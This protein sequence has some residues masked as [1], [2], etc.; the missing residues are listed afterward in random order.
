MGNNDRYNEWYIDTYLKEEQ[1]TMISAG[2]RH[3]KDEYGFNTFVKQERNPDNLNK[4]ENMISQCMQK[5]YQEELLET[6]DK[7]TP[8]LYVDCSQKGEDDIMFFILKEYIKISQA[9]NKEIILAKAIW[10]NSVVISTEERRKYID[11]NKLNIEEIVSKYIQFLK[12]KSQEKNDI[13]DFK[14]ILDKEIYITFDGLNN[15]MKQENQKYLYLY[16]DK[17]DILTWDEQR[18]INTLLYTRWS[19]NDIRIRVKINNGKWTWK[20]RT[21]STWNR[22]QSTHDYTE[23][24]IHEEKL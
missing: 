22:I 11:E 16:L 21:S 5:R 24:I 2:Y 3:L 6:L 10:D 14:D 15:L 7:K 1:C 18:R 17:T 8:I 4:L 23:I 13:Y 12:E 19:V 20:S 9:E